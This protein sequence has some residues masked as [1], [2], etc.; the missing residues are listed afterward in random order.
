M[1]I[2]IF[3]I[4]GWLRSLFASRSDLLLENPALRQQLSILRTKRP[5]PRMRMADRI[6]WV[7]LRRPWPRLKE[8]L[9]L[10]QPDT[11][12]RWHREGFRRYWRWKS[13]VRNAGHPS[14]K[15]EIRALVRRMAAENPTW[16]APRIHGELLMLWY[17]VS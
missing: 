17:D 8:V 11:V 14:T 15:A 12:V 5:R 16:G 6:F 9:V 7:T 1:L 2:R 10:V 13:R 4:A 3:T